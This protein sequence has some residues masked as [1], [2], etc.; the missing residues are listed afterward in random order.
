MW[1]MRERARQK[2]RTE[3]YRKI[4][5][6]QQNDDPGA[7][8]GG[9]GG[10]DGAGGIGGHD[11]LSPDE[12]QAETEL[13]EQFTRLSDVTQME[14]FLTYGKWDLTPEDIERIKKDEEMK[15]RVSTF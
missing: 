2:K 4:M 10:P 14:N 6:L 11:H 13:N 5:Q 15:Q 9:L 8:P 12:S 7:A 1:N 3:N